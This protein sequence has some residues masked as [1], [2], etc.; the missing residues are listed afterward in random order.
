MVSKGS[1]TATR[2]TG[3][4]SILTGVIIL[5]VAIAAAVGVEYLV[6]EY[7]TPA[8]REST[9]EIDRFTPI[10]EIP[11]DALVE[12]T[13]TL[14]CRS[15]SDHPA[16]ERTRTLMV[17]DGVIALERGASQSFI[18][19][20]EGGTVVPGEHSQ[21]FEWWRGEVRDGQLELEGWYREGTDTVK[22]VWM[23][24]TVAEGEMYLEGQRGPRSCTFEATPSQPD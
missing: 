16:F 3:K 13:G 23:S 7:R 11:S 1:M 18:E 24:G 2:Q 17:G 15:L 4:I 9:L 8:P 6:S 21:S 10:A 20:T 19:A 5:V 22:T 12:W 14:S